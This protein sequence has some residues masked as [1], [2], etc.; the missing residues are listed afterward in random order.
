MDAPPSTLVRSRLLSTHALLQSQLAQE[1]ERDAA[2]SSP[3]NPGRG[4]SQQQFFGSSYLAPVDLASDSDDNTPM[5]ACSSSE[6]AL[7]CLRGTTE[8]QSRHGGASISLMSSSDD[9]SL[10]TE[11]MADIFAAS[12]Q[13][14]PS[15]HGECELRRYR[16]SPAVPP[17]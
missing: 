6:E 1:H 13:Q 4:A 11:S 8:Q 12:Q 17:Y 3:A 7:A 10:L 2:Q 15:Q 5:G 14:N 16:C 9:D